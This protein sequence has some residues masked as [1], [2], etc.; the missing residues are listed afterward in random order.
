MMKGRKRKSEE[1]VM[2][3]KTQLWNFGMDH[4]LFSSRF[5]KHITSSSSLQAPNHR[6][7]KNGR[8]DDSLRYRWQGVGR[9]VSY[10]AG[11]PVRSRFKK[12]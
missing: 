6:K 5:N 8:E 11:P 9:K 12:A 4:N 2:N 1:I 10:Y 7:R 3:F